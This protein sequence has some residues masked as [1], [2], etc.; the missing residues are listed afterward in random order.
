MAGRAVVWMLVA[1]MCAAGARAD[2]LARAEQL[3]WNK[4]FSESEA[5]YR[6]ILSRASSR[7]AELGLARVILWS[8]RYAE[9][10]QRFDA[11][12]RANPKDVDA[13]E[14]RAQ[15]AYWSGDHRSAAR[16]FRRVLALDSGRGDSRK[17]LAEILA[18]M[19]PS[20]SVAFGGTRD[21]QPLDVNRGEIAATFFSDP[22]TR[23][24]I[25]SGAVHLDAG[26]RGTETAE[27][28]RVE[29]DTRWRGM[30][31]S[32]SVGAINGGFIGHLAAT[33]GSLTLRVER[34][35]E[36]ASATA[37]DDEAFSTSTTLRWSRER[38]GLIAAAEVSDKRYSDDNAG[39][40]LI[41]YAVTPVMKR[42]GWTIWAG[43]SGA[44]RDTDESRFGMT[45]VSSAFD[46]GFFRY[47]YRGEYDPYWTPDNLL[48]GRVV[49]AAER[50]V[51]RG[52]VKVHADGG[53]ARDR[54]RA[55]GPD[56][57]SGPFPP[58]VFTFAFDRDYQPWRIGATA[59]LV[60]AESLRLD[61]GVEHSVT[62]DYR[63]T[64]F[65]A[66]LVRRR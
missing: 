46:S 6:A 35:E 24:T 11:L 49:F 66:A 39:R 54:G 42:K 37:I 34:R 7:R 33:R 22:V 48:E 65:H 44:A 19:R 38:E 2:D 32:G 61:I 43:A 58:Q 40:A 3:A 60:I 52:R 20:Q 21:D 9:A 51:P 64:S 23:W 14:G 59:G 27:Y 56:V 1:V 15:A 4:R 50:E 55:F 16:D 30:G 28:V 41:A 5:L 45:A 31:W 12:I 57:G 47:S 13:L 26:R 63:S 36:L 29:G 53:Y 10:I 8:G 18:T 25:G 17:S 62:V